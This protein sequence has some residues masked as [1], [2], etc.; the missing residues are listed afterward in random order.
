MQAWLRAVHTNSMLWLIENLGNSLS[1]FKSWK[2]HGEQE[3]KL[4]VLEM[5]VL[6]LKMILTFQYHNRWHCNLTGLTCVTDHIKVEM[7]TLVYRWGCL[8]DDVNVTLQLKSDCQGKEHMTIPML[9]RLSPLP[10]FAHQLYATSQGFFDK[11]RCL[12]WAG[13]SEWS[14]LDHMNVVH[15]II[16]QHCEEAWFS[17]WHINQYIT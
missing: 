1:I 4:N 2:T 13:R 16:C 10:V 6:S 8:L 14:E 12:K 7:I 11:V 17:C 3:K 5:L 9:T 15:N